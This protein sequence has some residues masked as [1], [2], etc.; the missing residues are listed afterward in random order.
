MR[1]VVDTAV[2]VAAIRSDT[3]ASRYLLVAGLEARFT[4]LASVPLLIEYQAVMWRRELPDPDDD[5]V[6]ETGVNGQ[7][8]AIV[9]FNRRHFVMVTKQFGLD[10][11]SPAD[12]I[13]RLE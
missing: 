12:A 5:M 8:D 9:T 10:V 13:K 6:L 7:A 11:L 1:L 4:M 2:M 3:G